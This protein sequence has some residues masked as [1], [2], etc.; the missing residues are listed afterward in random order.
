VNKYAGLYLSNQ[1]NT[2]FPAVLDRVQTYLSENYKE[3]L[4]DKTKDHKDMLKS[5]ISQYLTENRISVDGMSP[6]DTIKKLLR[7]MAESSILTPYFN[8]EID[9][10]E[11][12]EINSWDCIWV[13]H[14]GGKVEQAQEH[15]LSAEHARQIMQR[16]LQRSKANMDYACPIVR[17][18]LDKNIRITVNGGFETLDEE[19]G[20]AASIR[21]VNPSHLTK[22]NLLDFGTLTSE[23]MDFL[24]YTY[25]YKISAM[26][27]GETDS[28]KTTLMS[29]IMKEAVPLLKKLITIENGTREFDLV[30]RNELGQIINSVLHL[31]TRES[32]DHCQEILQQKLIEFAMTMNPDYLCLA[33]VKGSEAFETMEASMTGHPTIGTTHT[34]SAETIPDRL[35]QLASIR[36]GSLSDRTLYSTAGKAFPILAYAENMPDNVRR[37][38]QISEC[39]L[40]NNY[41]KVVPLW[42]FETYS[43]EEVDGK[44]IVHGEF[45]KDNIISPALQA[46]LRRNGMPDSILKSLLKPQI[47]E[48][49][50]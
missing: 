27:A 34:D 22:Q 2:D 12:I 16:I 3:L 9:N 33:E 39:I 30:L 43:N 41:P 48:G 35:V 5:A 47:K 36:S 21:F 13:K 31:V 38:T 40:E 14:V 24:V 11:G 44:I 7:E 46:R 26:I 17:G 50:T 37:V 23:M 32:F 28:G 29:I 18:H 1:G 49:V 8:Y 25:R 10:V 6:Q 45:I 42:H 20:V 15:F 19:V 4:T